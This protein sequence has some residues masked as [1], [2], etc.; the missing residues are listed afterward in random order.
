M[1]AESEWKVQ[2]RIKWWK[3]QDFALVQDSFRPVLRRRGS[4]EFN[5]SCKFVF[6]VVKKFFRLSSC[7]NFHTRRKKKWRRFFLLV[8]TFRISMLPRPSLR[9]WNSFGRKRQSLLNLHSR[10]CSSLMRN[11]SDEFS[12]SGYCDRNSPLVRCSDD[13]SHFLFSF[14][15]SSLYTQFSVQTS[16]NDVQCHFTKIYL[17]RQWDDTRRWSKMIIISHT[18][19][20]VWYIKHSTHLNRISISLTVFLHIIY[21]MKI[22]ENSRPFSLSTPHCSSFSG[23]NVLA[24]AR[25]WPRF[26]SSLLSEE[27]SEGARGEAYIKSNRYRRQCGCIIWALQRVGPS[28][29][30]AVM[31]INLQYQRISSSS[32]SCPMYT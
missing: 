20:I 22:D 15:H 2:L 27:L 4:R 1:P 3:I 14:F 26:C 31:K 6:W 12:S 9:S 25:W 24:F 23:W 10:S 17:T 13:D 11:S 18:D 28:R 19:S 29:D 30:G 7:W 21:Y 32:A 5:F 16:L 8:W